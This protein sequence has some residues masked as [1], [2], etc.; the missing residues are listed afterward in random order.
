M[1]VTLN[2]IEMAANGF[3]QATAAFAALKAKRAERRGRAGPGRAERR[4][5][6][7]AARTCADAPRPA[8]RPEAAS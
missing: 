1:V 4:C 2:D 7:A 8:R 6:R 5:G 3:G